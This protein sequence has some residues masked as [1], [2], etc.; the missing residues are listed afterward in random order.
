MEVL[1]PEDKVLG[2]TSRRLD[3]AKGQGRW[4]DS[5]KLEK[6]M[7]LDDLVWHRVHYRFEYDGENNARIEGVE[8]I[9][10]ILLRPVVHI[11]AQQSYLCRQPGS[12]ARDRNRL[13]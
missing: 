9:S 1:D 12:S 13:Q 10:Q 11:L 4:Q 7:P 8:S 2:H 6:P 5:I 3:V